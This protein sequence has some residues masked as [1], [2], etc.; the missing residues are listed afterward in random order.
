MKNSSDTIGNRTRSL[1]VCSAVSQPTVPPRAPKSNKIQKHIREEI[2]GSFIAQYKLH[3]RPAIRT[4]HLA[5]KET[6]SIFLI[7]RGEFFFVHH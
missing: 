6:L 2:F 3:I 7:I 4:P 5:G 1:P